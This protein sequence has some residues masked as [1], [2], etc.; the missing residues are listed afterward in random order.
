MKD[1]ISR[2]CRVKVRRPTWKQRAFLKRHANLTDADLDK[3]VRINATNQIRRI[4]A[5]WNKDS[6][7]SPEG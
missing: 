1:N 6:S 5:G 4:I 3:M 7:E 2:P